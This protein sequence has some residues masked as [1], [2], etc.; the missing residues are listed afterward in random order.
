MSVQKLEIYGHLWM[1]FHCEREEILAFNYHP[2]L[3]NEVAKVIKRSVL[4]DVR[5][6]TKKGWITA[7]SRKHGEI[8]S[9][10]RVAKLN[11]M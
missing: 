10:D 9:A 3:E 6:A 4:T 7:I 2:V 11:H 5:R 8:S 1:C